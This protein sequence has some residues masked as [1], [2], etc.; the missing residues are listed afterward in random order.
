MREIMENP[1]KISKIVFD[2]FR[3]TISSGKSSMKITKRKEPEATQLREARMSF[4]MWPITIRMRNST[5]PEIL[6]TIIYSK[7]LLISK[8]V[9]LKNL[10]FL[11]QPNSSLKAP[12]HRTPIG[13]AKPKI[14]ITLKAS[15]NLRKTRKAEIPR[16]EAIMDL[17]NKTTNIMVQ[18]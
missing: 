9:T 16:A 5:N 12:P 1:M 11:I 8:L 15:L 13:E 17:C 4:V 6:Y 2:D 14:S 18:K 3:S 10:C 7:I